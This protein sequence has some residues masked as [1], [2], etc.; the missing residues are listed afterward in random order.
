MTKAVT[1]S[2]MVMALSA[3]IAD[4]SVDLPQLMKFHVH[5]AAAYINSHFGSTALWLESFFRCPSS[6]LRTD[7]KILGKLLIIQQPF[8]PN[9]HV[10]SYTFISLLRILLC[11]N[12]TG[13][14]RFTTSNLVAGCQAIRAHNMVQKFDGF[15]S[16]S[17]TK[18]TD[19][20]KSAY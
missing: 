4:K 2:L 9:E 19:L 7:D 17:L 5:V 12:N 20:C 18:L 3:V 14:I 15:V 10:S 11:I 16:K 1:I 8:W 13:T 6:D